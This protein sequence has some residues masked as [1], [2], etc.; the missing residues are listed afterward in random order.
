M[1][2]NADGIGRVTKGNLYVSSLMQEVNPIHF[3][4]ITLRDMCSALPALDKPSHGFI[5]T[6]SASKLPIPDSSID[7]VFVDPPF[8]DNLVYSELNFLWECWLRVFTN[9]PCETIVNPFSGKKLPQYTEGMSRAFE[10]LYRVLKPGRWVTIEFHNS[11]NSV[12]ISLQEALE[13][14]GFVIADVRVL[15]KKH[16]SIRQVQTTGAVK[17]DLVISAYKPPNEL[18][19]RFKLEAGTEV[20]VWDFIQNHLEHLPVFVEKLGQSEIIAERQNYL[21][22]DRM[23]AFHVQRGVTVPMSAS[24][25]YAGLRQRFPERDEMYFLSDQAPHYDEKRLLVNGAEQLDLFV[26]DERSAIQ[27][28]RR[29]LSKESLTLQNLQPL[30]MQEAQRVWEQHETPI[31][32]MVILEQNFVRQTNGLWSVPDPKKEADLEQL[33]S[34]SLL[35]EFQSYFE[36]KGKL[37]L[38]RTEALRAGFKDCWQKKDFATI[39]QIA[40]RIPDAVIQEDQSLLMY[41]DNASLLMGD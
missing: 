35:K 31:E 36:T 3:L 24:E 18:E 22:Y 15:D 7:Y 40:K 41:F 28:V 27:W 16:G 26:S 25:F 38:I 29:Q 34:R 17:K 37:K 6:N 2:Y 19:E 8:G 12:W 32:L 21:L 14:S 5:S 20:G 39:V 9:E 23:I 13:R 11:K 1:T 4:G 10:E 33:R 30:Y